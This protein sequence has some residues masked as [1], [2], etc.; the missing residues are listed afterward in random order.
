MVTSV[1][2]VHVPRAVA[3]MDKSLVALLAGLVVWYAVKYA[4]R[5]EHNSKAD[6]YVRIPY[7]LVCVCTI[8]FASGVW[9]VQTCSYTLHEYAAHVVLIGALAL[10]V[11]VLDGTFA[12]LKAWTTHPAAHISPVHAACVCA[13][14]YLNGA[15]L[16]MPSTTHCS[17]IASVGSTWLVSIFICLAVVARGGYLQRKCPSKVWQ[18]LTPDVWAAFQCTNT[19]PDKAGITHVKLERTRERY[20]IKLF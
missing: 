11:D 14:A 8:M 19:L 18:M 1:A 5:W 13:L 2:I 15:A 6:W 16:A 17:L 12:A 4:L 3:N 20:E 9:I 10:A 7:A